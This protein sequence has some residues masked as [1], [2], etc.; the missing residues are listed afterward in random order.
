MA[1]SISS[2]KPL[3]GRISVFLLL[4]ALTSL[5]SIAAAEKS[6]VHVILW[7]DTEDYLLPADDDATKRLAEML[8]H[9][10]IR[11][12]VKLVGEKARVLERR[13]RRDVI[14]AL[15]KH[16]IGYHANFH[17]VHPAPSEYLADC[18]LLDGI[19]EFVRRE[20][21]GAADVR[22]ILGVPTLACYGQPGSS[23][24][25]QAVAG[26]SQIGIA[27]HGVPCYVDEGTHVGLD[28]RPFWY[29]GTLMVYHL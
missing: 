9:R 15:K 11:A 12:T 28:N 7:F 10:G 26:L 13:G 21:G 24:G 20:G 5:H 3:S 16:D 18:G 14:A 2:M 17:S 19:A 23:W 6:T 4:F 29:A 27:P 8:T 22:R 1:V 25:P